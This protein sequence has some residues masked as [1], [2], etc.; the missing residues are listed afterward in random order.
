LKKGKPISGVKIVNLSEIRCTFC[1]V[2]PFEEG[3]TYYC[4][5]PRNEDQ[6]LFYSQPCSVLDWEVCPLK[7]ANEKGEDYEE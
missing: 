5:H 3:K 6:E 2:Y 1:E 4:V 7:E